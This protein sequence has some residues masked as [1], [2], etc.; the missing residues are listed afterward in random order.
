VQ[1]VTI[2][3][4][5]C[6]VSVALGFEVTSCR[7]STKHRLPIQK[8]CNWK[9][10]VHARWIWRSDISVF[11]LRSQVLQQAVALSFLQSI[12]IHW[13][14]YPCQYT[15]HESVIWMSSVLHSKSFTSVNCIT[16]YN[17][18]TTVWS[19]VYVCSHL[20]AGVAGLTPA[21]DMYVRVLCL[22]CVVY[23]AAF[24]RSWWLIQRS[25]TV[26][27]CQ[28]LCGLE[29]S[30]WCVLGHN[31]TMAPQKKITDVNGYE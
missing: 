18:Q 13:Q 28:I 29:T 4:I 5:C 3:I 21:E 11:G 31:R 10:E 12:N 27:L 23:V 26:F 24:A 14:D 22:S 15:N 20:I 2:Y 17:I 1:C 6:P 16:N 9:R 30:G 7:V 19:K 8:S 25:L